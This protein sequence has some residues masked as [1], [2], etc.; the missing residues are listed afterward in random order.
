MDYESP[1]REVRLKSTSHELMPLETPLFK[2]SMH[3]AKHN[4][5]ELIHSLDKTNRAY[6]PSKLM[7]PVMQIKGQKN[8]NGILENRLNP[9]S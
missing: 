5:K 7:V 3:A 8:T 6:S 9:I 2:H 1:V 4:N